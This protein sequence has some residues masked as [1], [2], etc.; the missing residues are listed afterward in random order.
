[1]AHILQSHRAQ[2]PVAAPL[3]PQVNAAAETLELVKSIYDEE[4]ETKQRGNGVKQEALIKL[5]TFIRK[6]VK[7]FCL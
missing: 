3:T 1:M 6:I 7:S 4:P 2:P 5:T